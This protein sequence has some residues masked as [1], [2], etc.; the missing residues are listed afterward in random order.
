MPRQ[1]GQAEVGKSGGCGERHLRAAHRHDSP[2]VCGLAHPAIGSASAACPQVPGSSITTVDAHIWCWVKASPIPHLSCREQGRGPAIF[3]M[4]SARCAVK[5]CSVG[6]ITSTRS[7]P[8]ELDAIFAQYRAVRYQGAV[9]ARETLPRRYG[10]NIG[11]RPVDCGRP[12]FT[13]PAPSRDPL[14]CRYLRGDQIELLVVEPTRG[15]RGQAHQLPAHLRHC[16]P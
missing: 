15:A 1:H 5:G 11:L 9:R 10:T 8:H 16:L 6:C 12:A 3:S 14:R 4:T 7:V 2:R 13:V